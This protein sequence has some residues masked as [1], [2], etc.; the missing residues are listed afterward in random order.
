MLCHVSENKAIVLVKGWVDDNYIGSSL[1]EA[2]TVEEAED[3]AISRLK[4]R[5]ILN[6]SKADKLKIDINKN[7]L[8]KLNLKNQKQNDNVIDSK[9]DPS[10]WSKELMEI[11]TQI[12]RLEWSRDDENLFLEKTLGYKRRNKI[13]HYNE[14]I[15]YLNILKEM[16]VKISNNKD[17]QYLIDESDNLMKDLSWNYRKGREYL[18]KEYNVSTRNEL[19]NIQLATFVNKLKSIKT[20]NNK[21]ELK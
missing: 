1:G 6:G 5:I 2:T 20:Q 7:D 19:N 21:N 13:I 15:K 17:K 10:D 3:K 16:E 4:Q 12:K 8:N 18:Q 14:L 11:D 9:Q